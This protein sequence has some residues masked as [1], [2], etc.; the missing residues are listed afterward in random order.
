MFRK[1]P[2]RIF[3][4]LAI[5]LAWLAFA[6]EGSHALFVDSVALTGNTITSGS[7]DLL[8]SNSQNGSSTT[9]SVDRPG[10]S[11][12]LSPGQSEEQYFLLK[13][14]S[15]SDVP[16]DIQFRAVSQVSNSDLKPAIKLEFTPVDSTGIAT[17][18]SFGG[19]LDEILTQEKASGVTIPAGSAQRFKM[20]VTL[21]PIYSK[22]N[23]TITYDLF[24]TGLQHYVA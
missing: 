10:F 5:V 22:Q 1:F 23:Q 21:L 12:L 3:Y 18:S 19:T 15:I 7:A 14:A 4:S 20:V 2:K 9:Y 6:V 11:F 16:F 24:F 8:I 13:N 17:G